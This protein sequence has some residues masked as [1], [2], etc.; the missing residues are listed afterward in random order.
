LDRRDLDIALDVDRYDFAIRVL[1][2]DDR[3]V[4]RIETAD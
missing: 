3:P 1:L 4:A 2:E